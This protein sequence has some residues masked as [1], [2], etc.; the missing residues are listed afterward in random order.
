MTTTVLFW[1]R[2]DVEG[3]ERLELSVEPDGIVAT[4][5][6][7]CLENGGFSASII[8]GASTPSGGR[9]PSGSNDGP[10]RVTASFRCIAPDRAGR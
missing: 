7:L 3:L 5:T 2:L 9:D 1:R 4:S 10:P 6:A 8:S